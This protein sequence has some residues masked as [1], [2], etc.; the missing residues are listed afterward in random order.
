M[1]KI[2]S[3]RRIPPRKLPTN[4]YNPAQLRGIRY[5]RALGKALIS[6]LTPH[7]I[8]ITP[9]P[10]YEYE[11][12]NPTT[13]F[14]EKA[15]CSPDFLIETEIGMIVIEVKLTFV[16]TAVE[17]LLNLYVPVVTLAHNTPLVAPLVIAKTLTPNTPKTINTLSLALDG[18]APR[19]VPVF[20]WLDKRSPLTW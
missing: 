17:K 12:A 15:I 10:W 14:T 3:A 20:Q 7:V 9:E 6:K 2:L 11:I 5:Q 4:H 1:L 19:S 13:K 8:S 16:F 18:K